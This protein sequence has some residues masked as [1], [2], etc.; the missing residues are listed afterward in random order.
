MNES[1]WYDEENA[2]LLSILCGYAATQLILFLEPII[3]LPNYL[4]IFRVDRLGNS[5][6]YAC[7]FISIICLKIKLFNEKR[8]GKS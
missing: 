1:K 5:L 8:N 3:H 7:M 6:T 4:S 2:I